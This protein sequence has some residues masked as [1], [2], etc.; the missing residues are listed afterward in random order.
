ME[1]EHLRFYIKIRALLD[2]SPTTIHEELVTALGYEVVS[3]SMVQKWSRKFR[4]NQMEIEDKP[5]SGH[6]V[7]GTTEEN[8]ELVRSVIDENPHCTYDEIEA[9]TELCRGTI[10]NI[11]HDR[12]KMKKITSRWVPHE[13]TSHQKEERVRI[14]RQNLAKLLND[15]W[16]TCN[17][18]TG[19]ETWIYCRQLGSKASNSYWA[20]EDQSPK[21]IVRRGQY[22]Q[23]MMFSIFFKS[24]GW[25]WIHAV[26][27]GQGIDGQY[28]I[29]NCLAP[30]I[31]ELKKQ[32]P[33][34]GVKGVKLLHD[35]AKCHVAQDVKNFLQEEGVGLMP[36][37]AYSPD[38]APCD[39]WLFDY[40]KRHLTDQPNK[41]YLFRAVSRIIENIPEKEWR[42]TFEKLIER[43]QLC[44]KNKGEYF[45]HLM[46]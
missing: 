14:C 17:I 18:I 21:T 6:P 7:S 10:S 29:K 46:Q 15:S 13:L 43:M 22:E 44:I 35:N 31:N 34:S 12:L 28:Y 32:R 24:N 20:G 41:K 25:L 38:L 2:I 45:E 26:D 16:R 5:R 42:K 1:K 23:K 8:V 33:I 3:Y 40:I 27:S 4:L 9:E 30:V 37:P 11:I 39:F 19:D 36:H